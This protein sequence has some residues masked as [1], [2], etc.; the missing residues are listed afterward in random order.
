MIGTARADLL[1]AAREL[2]GDPAA[3]Q[4]MARAVNPYG[5]GQA[6]ARIL[7]VIQH[8]LRSG[9]RPADFQP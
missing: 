8:V 6:S 3:Y 1:A 2:L 9:P 4:R 7:A 5:D